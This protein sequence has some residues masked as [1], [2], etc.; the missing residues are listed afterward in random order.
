MKNR[1]RTGI[2]LTTFV[3]A[4]I[5]ACAGKSAPAVNTVD[6]LAGNT[7]PEE[8]IMEAS[9][10]N[11]A[12]KVRQFATHF[13]P[14]GNRIL[15]ASGGETISKNSITLSG[16]PRWLLVYEQ[17]QRL[18]WAVFTEDGRVETY[19][20]INEA[21]ISIQHDFAPLPPGMPPLILSEGVAL[22][23]PV[24]QNNA[25]ILTH[26]SY[27]P[28]GRSAYITD[29][30]RMGIIIGD[31]TIFIDGD[32]L[33]DARIITDER[34]RFMALA[35][36]T[37]AYTH[38]VLGD[39]LEATS[40]TIVDAIT[41][42]A[43]EI[44]ITNGDVIEG[45]LPIWVD[46]DADG[47]R[48]IIVTQSNGQSGARVVV[49]RED[50]SVLAESEPIGKGFRWLHQIAAA[51]F[52]PDGNLEIALVQTPHIGGIIKIHKLDGSRLITTAELP[53]YSTHTIGS[54]NLDTAFTAD[55]NGDGLVELLLPNQEHTSLHAVQLKDGRLKE[56]WS[57]PL[58]S[59]YST[60]LVGLS[61]SDGK[62]TFGIGTQNNELIVWIT[63]K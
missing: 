55:I 14:D 33:P 32:F 29:D 51:Q 38:G 60:N 47:E 50:G 27:L 44:T 58:G 16:K 2:L 21:L 49:Y 22:H 7:E 17:D 35:R 57:S 4:F 9:P 56:I 23:I 24:P 5:S 42:T 62:L 1:F 53:G 61:T 20:L 52:I 30:G 13:R 37:D 48:E 31:H 34:G 26:A 6:P 28:D 63:E 10:S 3:L 45:L 12:D 11:Q 59:P 40:I 43:K 25:S 18:T 46:I 41:L 36:P 39:K 54:R 8:G 19:Q 15:A